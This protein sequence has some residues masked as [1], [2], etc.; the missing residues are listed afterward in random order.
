MNDTTPE[1][2]K[3]Q[4]DLIMSKTPSERFVLGLEMVESGR[5]LMIAGI[6]A[7]KPDI[8]EN[9]IVLELLK[10]QFLYDKSLFWLCYLIKEIKE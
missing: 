4:Y 2:H 1:M 6:K 7:Q 10:R 3:F 5:E 9:E 8:K